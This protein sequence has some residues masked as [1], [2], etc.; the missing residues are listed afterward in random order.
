VPLEKEKQNFENL[1]CLTG[2]TPQPN[3]LALMPATHAC[4]PHPSALVPSPHKFSPLRAPAPAPPL[5]A[6]ILDKLALGSPPPHRTAWARRLGHTTCIAARCNAYT[7]ALCRRNA[8]SS[9]LTAKLLRD[10]SHAAWPRLPRA[11]CQACPLPR[12]CARYSPAQL[13]PRCI[14]K[15]EETCLPPPSYPSTY[16]CRSAQRSLLPPCLAAILPVQRASGLDTTMVCHTMCKLPRS[17][18]TPLLMCASI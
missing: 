11:W 17:R 10:K 4:W 3:P 9:P 8:Q 13:P 16:P 12:R 14:D 7:A 18:C 5:A 2:R 15:H 1:F 6:S